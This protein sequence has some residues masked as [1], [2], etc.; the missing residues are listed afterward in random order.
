MIVIIMFY[1][2]VQPSTGIS[3][4][5]ELVTQQSDDDLLLS[6]RLLLQ[7]SNSEAKARDEDSRTNGLGGSFCSS[8][9]TD[10]GPSMLTA[11][12]TTGMKPLISTFLYSIELCIPTAFV[13]ISRV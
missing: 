13:S 11:K 1:L 2:G 5:S 10:D 9:T 8:R 4:A 12:D 3:S 6:A 7:L